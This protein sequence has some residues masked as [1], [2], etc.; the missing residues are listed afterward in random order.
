MHCYPAY[1]NFPKTF[2]KV[3]EKS[4]NFSI[5]KITIVEY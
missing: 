1:K 3:L 5:V 4:F 2:V